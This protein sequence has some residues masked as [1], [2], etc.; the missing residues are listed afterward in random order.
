M[1]R[2]VNIISLF[3]I[4][5]CIA[6]LLQVKYHVQNLSKDHQE[7]RKHIKEEKEAIHVL[8]AEWTYLNQPER[9][10]SIISNHLNLSVVKISQIHKLNND[11][12]HLLVENE[13]NTVEQLKHD[14]FDDD[15][16]RDIMNPRIRIV[17]NKVIKNK[18]KITQVKY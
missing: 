10:R 8:K 14:K 11:L 3:I 12:P 16:A 4:L 17:S 15:L 9:L 18:P 13:I 6:G 1:I 7:L 5:L 2:Y